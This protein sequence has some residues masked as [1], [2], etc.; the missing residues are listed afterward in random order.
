M[1]KRQISK[2]NQWQRSKKRVNSN[3]TSLVDMNPLSTNLAMKTSGQVS[4][5][6]LATSTPNVLKQSNSWTN[7]S[8]SDNLF[9]QPT[10]SSTP[11]ME[12]RRKRVL[13][14]KHRLHYCRSLGRKDLEQAK[15][16]SV[17]PLKI[18]LL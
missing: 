14:S 4:F 17:E 2:Q 15:L 6:P 11:K 1:G 13:V 12:Q 9:I 18:W 3:R 16:L 5:R 7:K 10:Y 8:S